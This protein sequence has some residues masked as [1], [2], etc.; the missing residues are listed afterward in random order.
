[1]QFISP[2]NTEETARIAG[3]QALGPL[4]DAIRCTIADIVKDSEESHSRLL[5]MTCQDKE[6]P[7][8]PVEIDTM[9][10][11][12][13][14]HAEMLVNIVVALDEHRYYR[15]NQAVRDWLF[16]PSG[17]HDIDELKA[18]LVRLDE[19]ETEVKENRGQIYDAFIN[20][21]DKLD[22]PDEPDTDI[23]TT[24]KEARIKALERL[25]TNAQIDLYKLRSD[26]NGGP[27]GG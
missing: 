6:K 27:A 9:A 18:I 4:I 3:R 10:T 16:G 12:Q 2:F 8:E 5:M 11:I 21:C 24:T 15:G 26:D 14:E 13:A 17:P 20:L 25:I 22:G 23:D 7:V 19:L 1:M